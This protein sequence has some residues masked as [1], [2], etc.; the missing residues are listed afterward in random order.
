MDHRDTYYRFFFSLLLTLGFPGISSGTGRSALLRNDVLRRVDPVLAGFNR[1]K[2]M[3]VDTILLRAIRDSAFPG[4]VLLVAKEGMVVHHKAYG[5]YGYERSAEKVDTSTIY[6]IA[7]LTKVI[8]TTTACMR[9]IDERKLRLNDRVVKYLPEFGKNGKKRITLFHLLTHTSGLPG[10]MPLYKNCRTP[11]CLLDSIY[12]TALVY[13]TGDTSVYSDL[14]FIV[15]GKVI[16][17]V[18]KKPLD[19]YCDSVFFTP[20]G[21]CSTMYNPPSRL[22]TRI[23][24]TEVDSLRDSTGVPLRGHVHDENAAVLG[25]ISGHAGLFSTAHDL[26]LMLEMIRNGGRYNG[27]QYL[28]RSTIAQFTRRQSSRSTRALGWD[29]KKDTGSWTGTLVSERAFI[30]TGFTGTSVVVD[31]VHD[32]IIILLTNRVYPRR[33]NGK[34]A[35]VR[36]EV[37]DA[38]LN[39]MR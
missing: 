18:C 30:H 25:G 12:S 21:M 39:A 31:P 3:R 13:P 14:G 26:A 9:L 10:W 2:L 22:Y 15:L 32:L 5:R 8:A 29:T 1:E 7:S 24:P 33:E 23:A 16:E 28:H 6:D 35:S 17:K 37:H 36:P 4:A 11:E 20:L 34:I 38:I 19:R 27:R